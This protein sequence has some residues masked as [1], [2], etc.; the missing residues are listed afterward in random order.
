MCS[1]YWKLN[2]DAK[3]KQQDYWMF[4]LSDSERKK[5]GQI[6]LESPTEK[7]SGRYKT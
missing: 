5:E 1:F 7:L 6:L 4:M 2:T 3:L